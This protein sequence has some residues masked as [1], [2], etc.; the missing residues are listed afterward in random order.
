ML[1]LHCAIGESIHAGDTIRIHVTGRHQHEQYLFVEAAW[2]QPLGAV[3]GFHASAPCDFGWNAH[4]L[5]LRDGESFDVGPVFVRLEDLRASAS[6][7]PPIRE[8]RLHLHAS[9]TLQFTHNSRVR[10]TRPRLKA[11]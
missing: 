8:V 4:V 2:G 11:G 6:V 9:E 7:A 1:V 5:A 10:S 3:P